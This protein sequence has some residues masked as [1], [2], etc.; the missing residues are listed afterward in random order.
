MSPDLAM[1]ATVSLA[2]SHSISP[3]TSSAPS[4]ANARSLDGCCRRRRGRWRSPGRG[5][6]IRKRPRRHRIPLLHG[7]RDFEPFERPFGSRKARRHCSAGRQTSSRRPAWR[8]PT[9]AIAFNPSVGRSMHADARK[10]LWDA[11][12][13]AERVSRQIL[14]LLGLGARVHRNEGRVPAL[15]RTPGFRSAAREPC[16]QPTP[17]L[18]FSRRRSGLYAVPL[19][20]L[21]ET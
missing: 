4:P 18:A 9:S 11:R 6:A 2:V 14:R 17:N 7:D 10:L 8:T 5:R 15:N 21:W 3:Q 12:H 19:R 16:E 20:A 13:A 1:R